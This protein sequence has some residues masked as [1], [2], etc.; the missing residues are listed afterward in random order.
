LGLGFFGL[1]KLKIWLEPFKS[2]ALITGLKICK[3]FLEFYYISLLK[4]ILGPSGLK[5][6]IFQPIGL[7]LLVLYTKKPGPTHLYFDNLSIYQYVSEIRR[8]VW[9]RSVFGVLHFFSLI[10]IARQTV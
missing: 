3:K 1:L 2:W 7:G 9:L 6:R 4:K 8:V 10:F 5:S